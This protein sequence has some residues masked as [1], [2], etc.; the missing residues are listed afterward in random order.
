MILVQLHKKLPTCFWTIFAEFTLNA[1]QK[2]QKELPRNRLKKVASKNKKIADICWK[3]F[4]IH[5]QQLLTTKLEVVTASE[6]VIQ[7]LVVK[8][9]GSFYKRLSKVVE[10]KLPKQF[11][12]WFSEISQKLRKKLNRNFLKSFQAAYERVSQ[13]YMEDLHWSH[14]KRFSNTSG[15]SL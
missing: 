11:S 5:L 2:F 9:P 13:I 1:Y 12:N 15:K 10:K 8:L 4:L 14:R 7:I 3:C 6:S